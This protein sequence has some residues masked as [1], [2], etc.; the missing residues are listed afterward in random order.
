MLRN[1][2]KI[3][4]MD[5]QRDSFIV[6]L[7]S[8]LSEIGMSTRQAALRSGVDYPFLSKIL[9]GK[10]PVSF[11]VLDKLKTIPELKDIASKEK[12]A[13]IMRD[14]GVDAVVGATIEFLKKNPDRVPGIKKEISSLLDEKRHE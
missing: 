9:S 6:E 13:K 8:R 14:F 7:S 3:I 1:S 2:V 11:D 4:C 5:E 12:A 10:S